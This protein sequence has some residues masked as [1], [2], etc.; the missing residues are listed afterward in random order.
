MS[1]RPDC[2]ARSAS[3]IRPRSSKVCPKTS[4]PQPRSRTTSAVIRCRWCADGCF[5]G[6]LVSA[7]AASV[8]RRREPATQGTAEP[9]SDPMG[10]QPQLEQ[11]ELPELVAPQR[12][13]L[14]VRVGQQPVDVLR[15]EQP[16]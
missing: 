4:E 10:L 7:G 15:P 8:V 6:S 1:R 13:V 5:A 11:A 9:P 16:P 14:A 12:G 3:T 2:S